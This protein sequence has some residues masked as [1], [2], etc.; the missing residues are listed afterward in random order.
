MKGVGGDPHPLQAP[1]PDGIAGACMRALKLVF[2]SALT[3]VRFPWTPHLR[4]TLGAARVDRASLTALTAKLRDP[5]PAT[6]CAG[7]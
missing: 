3:L 5:A 1:G 4:H 6:R 7:S 2:S